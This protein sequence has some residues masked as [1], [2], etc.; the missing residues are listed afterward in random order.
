MSLME[1]LVV[2]AIIGLVSGVIAV[3]VIGHLD[4]AR[5]T[6][7]RESARVLRNAVSSYRMARSGDECPTVEMLVADQEIDRASKTID[8]WDKP[9][10]IECDERAGVTVVSGGPD[11]RLGTPDDIRVPDPPAVARAP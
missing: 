1:I 9:F 6:T 8:A 3:A 4:K 11:K 5:I 10:S 2:L 7:S